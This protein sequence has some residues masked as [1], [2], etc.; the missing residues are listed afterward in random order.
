MNNILILDFGNTRIK[1]LGKTV[2]FINY[3]NAN[4]LFEYIHIHDISRIY[5]STVNPSRSNLFIQST[6]IDSID[7]STLVDSWNI[8]F[9]D[10]DGM[11]TDRKLALIGARSLSKGPL[12]AIDCGTANTV[13]ILGENDKC[14]G[15]YITPGLELRSK[16][17]GNLAQLNYY[18][19]SSTGFKNGQSTEQAIEYGILFDA[20]GGIK[21]LL[22]L[23]AKT[24]Q[25]KFK[26]IYL[27]GG[28]AKLI[29]G[30]LQE[31]NFSVN[32]Q[33]DLVL[34]GIKALIKEA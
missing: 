13:N 6:G 22:G 3:E 1:S 20:A 16:S 9:S 29:N 7:V 23:S 30:A 21:N 19:P 12:V 31:M 4:E 24:N 11:G 14:L 2:E 27:T 26:E 32:L 33:E 18:F 34:K 10:I 25:F 8:D 5:Y 28:N 15:G 17:L